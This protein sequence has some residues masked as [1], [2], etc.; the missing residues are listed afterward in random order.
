MAGSLETVSARDSRLITFQETGQLTPMEIN[1]L[2]QQQRVY[3]TNRYAQSFFKLYGVE[4]SA[5]EK[6]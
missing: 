6:N 1:V 3:V 2:R 5:K 4:V